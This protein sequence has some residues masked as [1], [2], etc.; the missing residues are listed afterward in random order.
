VSNFED[1][2]VSVI[3]GSTDTVL[4]TIPVG[5]GPWGVVVNTNTNRIY[6]ANYLEDTVTVISD[7]PPPPPVGVPE[8]G[9][10]VTMLSSLAMTLW[11]TLRRT[12]FRNV[13]IVRIR[14]SIRYLLTNLR[15]LKVTSEK[16]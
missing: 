13:L 16:E 8:M 2:T 14:R 4:T 1:D 7:I 11:F 12:A 15:R 3:D 6:V 9:L 10:S 5:D